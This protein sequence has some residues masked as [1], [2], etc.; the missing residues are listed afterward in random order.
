MGTRNSRTLTE[1]QIFEYTSC[2]IVLHPSLRLM[3]TAG[4]PSA[5]PLETEKEDVMEELSRQPL[6]GEGDGTIWTD[7]SRTEADTTKTLRLVLERGSSGDNG[8]T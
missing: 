6:P 8:G 7:G 4:W 5:F 2:I 3:N 1:S